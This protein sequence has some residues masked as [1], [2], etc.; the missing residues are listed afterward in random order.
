MNKKE[1]ICYN[2]DASQLIGN[3]EK[4][5]FPES[6]EK[7]QSVV[8]TANLDL[9]PRGAGTKLL[10]G[11][12]PGNSIIIDMNKMNKIIDIDKTKKIVCVEA[13]ISIKELNEKLNALGF[14]F[15]FQQINSSSTIGGM[16]ATNVFNFRGEYGKIKDWIEEINFINGR[17][18]LM[19]TSKSDLGDVCGMEGITGIIVNV[20]LRIIPLVKKSISIF[21]TDNLDEILSIARRL[22]LEKQAIMLQVL[23][24][25]ISEIIG[26][27]KKYNLIVEFESERGKIRGKEYKRILDLK[28]KAYSALTEKEYYNQEDSKFFF[29]KL[30]DFILHLEV[31]QIPYIA[32]LKAGIVYYFFKDD[33]KDKRKQTIDLM[34]RMGGKFVTGIGIK[35]KGFVDN[36]EKKIIQ[37]VKLRHDPFGKLNKGKFI[38]FEAKISA[39][40]HLEP[41]QRDE[42][43]QIEPLMGGGLSANEF[44][45]QQTK[46]PKEKMQEF[47]AKVEILDKTRMGE[48]S[49]TREQELEEKLPTPTQ[50]L[51]KDYEQTYDSELSKERAKKIEDF[52][53]NV[54]REITH[55]I[56]PRVEETEPP[57]KEFKINDPDV[58]LRGKLNKEEQDTVNSILF[59]GKKKDE[60]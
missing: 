20:K 45:E 15:P 54:A 21:Q 42:I 18:E 5:V 26:L 28:N 16:V 24:E 52:A 44:E 53:K 48:E 35:R 2:T 4:V 11:S 40:K 56:E 9:V 23:P 13:G 59:G 49:E 34:R 3:A 55:K 14:E 12:I 7:V 22:K 25:K 8:K 1:L 37:R 58:E 50:A 31:N 30:K 19:K 10:G 33:E 39:G 17:G 51:L 60:L 32:Y 6:I 38:D 43:E 27:P 57:K 36:F 46:T 29:D 41:L 47:I